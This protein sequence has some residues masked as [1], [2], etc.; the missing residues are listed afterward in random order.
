VTP[1][2]P[3]ADEA[4]REDATTSLLGLSRG[5]RVA[6]DRLFKLLHADLRAQASAYLGRER[7]DHTLQATAL[8]NEAWMRMIDQHKVEI[9]N[10]SHFLALAS[11][12]MRRILVD[13]A[14][15]KQRE[16]R[17]GGRQAVALDEALVQGEVKD[18]LDLVAVDEALTR[19]KERS[20]RL[21]AVVEMRFFGGM[22]LEEV[23]AYLEVDRA[24]VVRDWRAARALLSTFLS[25]EGAG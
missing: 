25:D 20:K 11:Q 15:T 5:D 8:V 13:H 1:G 21:A 12:A 2:D 24:T 4:L 16:K 9:S 3:Q 22:T 23:A 10:K 6:K 19:L 7:R 17:G 14:R 18:G